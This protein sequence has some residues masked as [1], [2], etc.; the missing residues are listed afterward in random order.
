MSPEQIRSGAIGP[1]EART[2][3][4]EIA[5]RAAEQ[6]RAVLTPD[7]AARF[8]ALSVLL[9]ERFRGHFGPD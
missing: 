4:Q 2:R 3:N 8:D 9:P 7:Q 5:R 6:I 1:E